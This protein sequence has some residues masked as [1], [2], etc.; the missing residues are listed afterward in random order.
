[1]LNSY[2]PCIS[3]ALLTITGDENMIQEYA[4]DIAAQMEIK[5]SRVS[6]MGGQTVKGPFHNCD[7]FF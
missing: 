4:A 7:R 2:R 6:L 3:T 1:M 5:L